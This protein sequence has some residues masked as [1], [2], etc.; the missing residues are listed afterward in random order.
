MYNLLDYIILEFKL[1]LYKVF[2]LIFY[3]KFCIFLY[4]F[5]ALFLYFNSYDN[6][7]KR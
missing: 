4:Y 3:Y 2:I 5:F 1:I 6:I 7:S